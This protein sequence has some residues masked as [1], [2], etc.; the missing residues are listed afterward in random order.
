MLCDNIIKRKL[1]H[2]IDDFGDATGPYHI[3]RIIGNYTNGYEYDLFW[4]K[5]D[6]IV[7]ENILAVEF[8]ATE[9]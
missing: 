3:R 2:M 6:L 8:Y 4:Q 5:F 7:V 9:T 1:F